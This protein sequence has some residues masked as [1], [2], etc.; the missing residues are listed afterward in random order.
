MQRRENGGVHPAVLIIIGVFLLIILA[1]IYRFNFT[2][3][4]IFVE[5]AQGQVLAA[6][7]IDALSPIELMPVDDETVRNQLEKIDFFN[8]ETVENANYVMYSIDLNNDRV[9]EWIIGV[10][11]AEVCGTGGCPIFVV[12]RVNAQP[13]IV[14]DFSP[15]QAVS[16]NDRQT[17]GWNNLYFS[18]ADGGSRPEVVKMIFD[19]SRYI[20]AE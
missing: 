8:G 10:E 4:D 7:E 13:Y 2:N 3:D 6:N 1:G 19:G 12:T 14:A 18:I 15:A 9:D 16:V 20:D 5:T 11:A 17:N